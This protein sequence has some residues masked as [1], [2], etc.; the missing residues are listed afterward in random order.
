M[1]DAI[2]NGVKVNPVILESCSYQRMRKEL[3]LHPSRLLPLVNPLISNTNIYILL[4][5]FSYFVCHMLGES[6]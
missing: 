3:R 4:T 6:V 5:L 2:Q 1:T